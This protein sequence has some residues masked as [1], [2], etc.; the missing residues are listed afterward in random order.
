MAIVESGAT[1]DPG[2]YQGLLTQDMGGTSSATD[3]SF[4]MS[5]QEPDWASLQ[6]QQAK[7]T[8]ASSAMTELG[9]AQWVAS[10]LQTAGKATGDILAYLKEDEGI[11]DETLAALLANQQ[12][13]QA[14]QQN[15]VPIIAVGGIAL[16][17][18]LLLTKK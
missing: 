12:Q 17:L 1:F 4:G 3:Y 13:Q 15:W 7:T 11:S 9:W 14:S 8:G 6:I 5:L 2:M 18:V 10:I 16:L